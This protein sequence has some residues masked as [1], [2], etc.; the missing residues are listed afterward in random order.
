MKTLTAVLFAGGESRRMGVDKATLEIGGEPLWSRQLRT[1]REL[2]PEKIMV[3]ARSRPTWCPPEVEVIFDLPPLRG[4]LSGLAA[5]LAAM[6][7]SHALVLAADLP[8]IEAGFLREL[9]QGT[10][11]DSGVVPVIEDSFEP[12]CAVYPAAAADVVLA[13]LAGNNFSLHAV[14]DI[15]RE[16]QLMRGLPLEPLVRS[17][18][19]NL[20]RPADWQELQA[21]LG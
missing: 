12:L 2:R 14:L 5:V 4:P 6:K 8:L 21:R 15:L 18:F 10:A 1:L 7:T 9:W 3:S 17:T 16:R 19:L 13:A 11:A 20:N